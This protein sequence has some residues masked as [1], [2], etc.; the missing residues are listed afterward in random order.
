VFGPGSDEPIV[1]YEG[2]G[3]SDRRFLHADE[4]GSI[5]AVTS[6]AAGLLAINRYDEYG[7]T[8][9]GAGGY[10]GRFLYTGQ[11]YFPG[12][13]VSYYKNRMYD[14]KS[15]RFMQTDPIGYGGGTNLYAYV[16][17]DPVNR[18]DPIGLCGSSSVTSSDGYYHGYTSRCA[19]GG[20]GFIGGADGG[21]TF[22][23]DRFLDAVPVE[24]GD[25]S[26][27]G[28]G[29]PFEPVTDACP[30][31]EEKRRDAIEAAASALELLELGPIAVLGL[32]LLLSG[33]TPE[34]YV[35]RGGLATPDNLIKGTK[36]FQQGRLTISGF[37]AYSAPN[38][39]PGQ[40]AVAVNL[41][42]GRI[43]YT[44]VR[45]LATMGIGVVSTPNKNSKIH[46]TVA[47]PTPLSRNLAEKISNSLS[48]IANPNACKIG[49]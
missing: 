33:D 31:A 37:S 48:R 36:S 16:K 8:Q 7:R 2:S 22:P 38:M 35:V 24:A 9:T 14:T 20:M 15:G 30:T 46:V 28:A 21:I 26:S 34:Q 47:V 11:R 45:D 49:G 6:S 42:N 23:A 44:T 19:P 29:G 1:W 40:I 32:P 13:G 4:R 41:P 5:V 43:S 25:G 3:T 17:G 12:S 39:T 18:T 10:Y 27:S